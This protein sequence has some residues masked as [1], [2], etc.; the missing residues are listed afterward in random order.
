MT[1]CFL[2]NIYQFYTSYILH[3]NPITIKLMSIGARVD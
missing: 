3:N 2:S 1:S